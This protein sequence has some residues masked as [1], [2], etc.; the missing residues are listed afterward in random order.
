MNKTVKRSKTIMVDDEIEII[1][2]RLVVESVNTDSLWM[3]LNR[4]CVI[5]GKSFN[6]GDSISIILYKEKGMQK[7]GGCLTSAL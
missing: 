3:K 1:S 4:K 6:V 7:S 2:Q 5:T